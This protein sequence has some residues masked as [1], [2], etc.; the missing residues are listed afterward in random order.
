MN[1]SLCSDGLKLFDGE[2]A[3]FGDIKA[4]IMTEKDE[5]TYL[6]F[7]TSGEDYAQF[8]LEELGA[9][10]RV[11]IEQAGNS[12]AIRIKASYKPETFFAKKHFNKHTH[13]YRYF[14][15]VHRDPLKPRVCLIK[16]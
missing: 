2:N 8:A 6:E 4:Y 16:V 9:S 12:S 15:F 14:F 11:S 7:K 5:K 1:F 3:L 10:L 13:K